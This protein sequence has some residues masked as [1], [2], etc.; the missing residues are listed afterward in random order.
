MARAG[1]CHPTSCPDIRR[2]SAPDGLGIAYQV[3]LRG[4]LWPRRRMEL[5]NGQLLLSAPQSS[6]VEL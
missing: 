1:T 6:L 3:A 5:P 2:A 4:H